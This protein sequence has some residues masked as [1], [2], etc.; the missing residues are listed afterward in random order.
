MH[1]VILLQTLYTLSPLYF[2][3]LRNH[4]FIGAILVFRCPCGFS[5]FTDAGKV[6][7]WLLLPPPFCFFYRKHVLNR[8]SG[9]QTSYVFFSRLR[10]QPLNLVLYWFPNLQN[11]YMVLWMRV[12]LTEAA[13]FFLKNLILHYSLNSGVVIIHLSFWVTTR[14]GMQICISVFS[15]RSGFKRGPGSKHLSLHTRGFICF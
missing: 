9:N 11:N 12:H 13:F 4:I 14:R 1:S 2:L 15:A 6:H 7:P 5:K 8:S 10:I 3:L